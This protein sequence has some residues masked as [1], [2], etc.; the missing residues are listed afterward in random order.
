MNVPWSETKEQVIQNVTSDSASGLTR[1]EAEARLKQKG[2][3]KLTEPVKITFWGTFWDEVREP[4]ILLLLVVG[5][6]YTIWG[7]LRD[8]ATIFTVI[9]LLVMT[10]VFTEYR[11][12]SAI[13]ALRK[14]SPST[15][16]VIRDGNY[17]QIPAEDI[18]QGDVVPLEAGDRIPA[19]GRVVV[20]FGLQT[21]ESPLTGESA[22]V[23]KE[24]KVLAEGAPVTDRAN[25]VFA[26]TTVTGGTGKAVVTATAMDTEIG[27]IQGLVQEARQP[28]TPLQRAMRELSGLLVWVAVFFSVLIP[29][30]GILQGKLYSEM[31]LTGLSLAFAVIPEELPIII[32]MVLALGALALSK[33]HVLIRN[34]RAAET[35]GSVTVIITDK[36]GT[37]TENKMTLS[38]IATDN[39]VSNLPTKALSLSDVRL[40]KVGVLTST[41]K[42]SP[43]GGYTGDPLEVALLNAAREDG[44]SPEEL[45]SQY[46]KFEEF[47]FDNRRKMMSVVYYEVNGLVVYAKGAPEV[48]LSKC[49]RIAEKS[50]EKEKTREDEAAI[51]KQAENMAGEA[52]RVIAFAYKSVRNETPLTRDE[53]ESGLAFL[54]LAGMVDPPRPG[55]AGAIEA[56]K[57]AGIRTIMVTGDLPLTAEKIAAE[58]GIDDGGKCITG[59]ELAEMKEDQ[60]KKEVKGVSIFARINPAQKLDIVRALQQDGEVVAVTGDGINDAPALKSADIGIAMGEKGTEAAR[61]AAGM[62]LTDDSYSSIVDGVREGR[63]IFDNLRKGVLYYLG[64]K[65]ALV[66]V[67][68]VPLALGLPFPFAPIQ[69]VLLELFMDLAASATFVAEPMEAGVMQRPPPDPRRRFIDRPMMTDMVL[70]ALSLAAAVLVNYF[71]IMAPYIGK[72]VPSAIMIQARTIAF[73]TWMLGHI[74]LA[75]TMRSRRETLSKIGLLTNQ[76]M[77]IWAVA[78]VVFLIVITMVIE[79]NPLM[80]VTTLTGMDWLM[81]IGVPFVTVFWHEIVKMIGK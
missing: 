27:K 80:R 57:E 75:F 26:G 68:L 48:I 29:V 37:I 10:E 14:L 31:V 6:L 5:V 54:G 25:M 41:I 17:L 32:T 33:R 44:I 71:I 24:D 1:A 56:T 65:I 52:M 78:V 49:Y 58:V 62:V 9:F 73:A 46:R 16:P 23:A 63:R 15:T 67:F 59:A 40:L 79:L 51:M 35:L 61:E 36:T 19:D 42:S 38:R 4:M 70:A 2:P 47:A 76:V 22:P 34:L 11:A 69:I 3:N 45:Q 13:S 74:F 20:S 39:S 18:V 28:R 53:A 72:E 77:L 8:A 66:L 60:I 12:H 7:E 50:G 43:E 55:V 81:V 30:V 21:D 64:V